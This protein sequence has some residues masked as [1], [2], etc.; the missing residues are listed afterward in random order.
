MTPPNE[1]Q[2]DSFLRDTKISRTQCPKF[3]R[4]VKPFKLL[5]N[6]LLKNP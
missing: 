4:I 5:L 3:N 1:E 2:T 6:L